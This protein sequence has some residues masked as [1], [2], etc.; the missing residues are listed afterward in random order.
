[1]I[2]YES[3]NVVVS[4][5]ETTQ[6]DSKDQREQAREAHLFVDKRDGQWEPHWWDS[7]SDQP[8]YTFDMA[9][10]V[11]DQISGDIRNA[12][13]GIKVDPAGG[14]ATKEDAQLLDGLIRNIQNISNAENIFNM[15]A[16]DMVTSGIS[17]WH[18]KQKFVDGDSFDQDLVIEPVANFLDSVW[19][20]SSAMMQDGSDAKHG[21]ILQ[22]MGKQEYD[23]KYP[24]GSGL[25]LS[26][27]S[28][29][30]AYFDKPE[31]VTVGQI[32][33][34]KLKKRTLVKLSNGMVFDKE[35]VES[36]L[37]EL[38]AAGI[39][40]KDE[41]TRP[42]AQVWSRLFDAGGW[43]KDAQ[44]TVFS[45]IPLIPT[46]GNFKTFENKILYRGAVEKILDACRVYNYTKS[47][48]LAEGALAP[49]AKYMM[50]DKQVAG[51]ED[52][53]ATMN[54]N[55][56]PVQLFNADPENPGAPQQNG[57]AMINP[58]LRSQ[59]EDMRNM[60]AQSAGLF[61]ATM[62]D[63][64]GLQSGV[65]I[66]NLQDRGGVGTSKYFIPQEIAICHTARIII[67]AI[68]RV[69]NDERTLRIL[70]EDG[71]SEM[72]TV[73]R[74]IVDEQTGQMVKLNDLTVGKYDVVCSAGK[75]F[76]N[77]QQE[78]VAA[79]TEV[80][81]IDPTI[82]QTGADILFKNITAPGMDLIA[83]RKRQELFNAGMIPEEQM[84]DEEK[85]QAAQAAQSPPPP[86][87]NMVLAEAE[88]GKAE[89][90]T[91]KVIVD[92]Q[93]AQRREDRA[94]FELQQKI[95][96]DKV[97]VA[98]SQSDSEF[99]QFMAVQQQQA[100]QTA[101]MLDAIQTQAET[102]K[103]LREAMGVDAIVGPHNQKAY[104]DQAQL[105]NE[106]QDDV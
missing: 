99:K 98:Q 61:A 24:D 94:D 22:G 97:K 86:D 25:S 31:T 83:A 74:S 38:Q 30:E 59:A 3:H 78:T 49:R 101:A 8:R 57:G 84:T 76:S 15:A 51:H 64:P 77:R 47:R 16:R 63:N 102:L 90:Q 105:V 2:D 66:E 71:T 42:A 104:I 27:G 69:Y 73:N 53:F 26:V 18:V 55:N 82:L 9:G 60:V 56:D 41:R 19:L 32:Y 11:V 52:T 21:F 17:G 10:Q 33:Y 85:Q 28:D 1:M 92:A 39:T 70:K 100:A 4:L 48:E 96:L 75:S 89:A 50:T 12:D 103:V 106:A 6:D 80:A 95:E 20:D 46:Y 44:E 43:L 81:T 68:P 14:E 40:V 65:A 7:C 37:D 58:G 79:M 91:N 23:D 93:V 36:V 87:P 5:L 13:F 62:G 29:A 72:T 45:F 34:I 35:E 54:T 88:A 67:K